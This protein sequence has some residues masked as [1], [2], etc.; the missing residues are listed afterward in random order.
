MTN[1]QAEIKGGYSLAIIPFLNK[2]DN[3]LDFSN[4][5]K[6]FL[7]IGSQLNW[8][9]DHKNTPAIP[10]TKWKKKHKFAIYTIKT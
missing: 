8:L 5:I 3:W 9:K 1:I 10:S 6:T 7:I 2:A 4:S